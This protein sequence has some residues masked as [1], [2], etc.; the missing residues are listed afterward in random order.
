MMF[1]SGRSV[2]TLDSMSDGHVAHCCELTVA[3]C[4]ETVDAGGPCVVTSV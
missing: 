1:L 4:A 2:K 3:S